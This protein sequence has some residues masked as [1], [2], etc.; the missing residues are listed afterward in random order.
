[1]SPSDMVFAFDYEHSGNLDYL[2]LYR[3][4]AGAIYILKIFNG[5]FSPFYMQIAPGSGIGGYDLKSAEDHAIAFDYGHSGKLDHIAIIDLGV[6]FFGSSK[7]TTE[8]SHLYIKE[9]PPKMG[10][11]GTTSYQ[12]R[13][14]PS[15]S[16]MS[17]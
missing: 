5:V 3:P 1:M 2:A 6:V 11:E 16:T 14:P 8:N 17:L 7:T 13:I 12:Q 10:L 9:V 15:L 4:G